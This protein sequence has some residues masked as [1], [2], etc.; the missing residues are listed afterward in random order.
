MLPSRPA[1]ARCL[2]TPSKTLQRFGPK[3]V[4]GLPGV[5]VKRVRPR[6]GWKGTSGLPPDFLRGKNLRALI[7]WRRWK[8]E[9]R[10]RWLRQACDAPWLTEEIVWGT[11]PVEDVWLSILFDAALMRSAFKVVWDLKRKAA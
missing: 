2:T 5:G 11:V 10:L 9:R 3:R 4:A 6:G 8:R 7:A 1:R